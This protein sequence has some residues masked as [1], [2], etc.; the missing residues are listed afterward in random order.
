[1]TIL[2]VELVIL[3]LPKEKKSQGSDGFI[4]DFYQMFKEE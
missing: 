1:M 4:G 3:N 2:K